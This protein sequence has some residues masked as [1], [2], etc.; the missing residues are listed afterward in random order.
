VIPGIPQFG[1]TEAMPLT[2][3]L[4]NAGALRRNDRRDGHTRIVSA[5]SRMAGGEGL[6]RWR[7]A[8]NERVGK[9]KVPRE[10]EDER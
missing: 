6:S 2:I 4:P 8:G 3:L 9:R 7:T 5:G 1:A 10:G